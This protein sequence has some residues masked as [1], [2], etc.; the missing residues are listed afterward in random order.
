MATLTIS[1]SDEEMRRLEELSK[2]EGLTV[3]QIVRLS[4]CDFIGQPNDV[5][6]AAAKRALEKNAELYRRLS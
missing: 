5:F 2:R 3:E 1:L 6:H 4:V